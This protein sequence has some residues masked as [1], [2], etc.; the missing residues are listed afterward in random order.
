MLKAVGGDGLSVLLAAQ[1]PSGARQ[2]SEESVASEGGLRL[3][4]APRGGTG[5]VNARAR[6]RCA[7][8]GA[9]ARAF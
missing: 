1:G 4:R 7:L 2:A 8:E 3:G 5:R 9:D 6:S